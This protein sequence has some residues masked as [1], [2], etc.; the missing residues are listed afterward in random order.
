MKISK[1]IL[2]LLMVILFW[3]LLLIPRLITKFLGASGINAI[4]RIVGF[5]V[6]AIGVE[7]IIGAILSIF[8]MIGL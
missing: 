4:S 6:I 5:I 7:Y 1:G 8:K 2:K 3:T